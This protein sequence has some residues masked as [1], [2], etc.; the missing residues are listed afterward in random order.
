MITNEKIEK[1]IEIWKKDLLDLSLRN[2]LINYKTR[3]TSSIPILEPSI[4]DIF[5]TLVIKERSMTFTPIPSEENDEEDI[6]YKKQR[7]APREILCNLEDKDLNLALNRLR[8]RAKTSYEEMGINTLFIAFGFIKWSENSTSKNPL[9]SPILLVPVEI[10]RKNLASKC[11]I[12][13]I[14]EDIVINPTLAKKLEEF[15]IN[16]NEIY[17]PTSTLDKVF[18]KELFEKVAEIIE[19]FIGWEIIEKA[20]ISLF[21]F[22]K[23]SMYMDL[24]KYSHLFLEN[25]VLK[26]IANEQTV[27]L[28]EINVENINDLDSIDDPFNSFQV[29]DADS[30]QQEAI[31][32]IKK[33]ASL[34]IQGPPGTGKS[35]TI[36]N[37]IAESL[38]Q[39]KTVLFVSEKKAALEV[40]KKRLDNCGLGDFCLE[41]HSKK[42]RKRVVL[43]ELERT[44]NQERNRLLDTN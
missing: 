17:E 12:R 44:L 5:E 20:E 14:D 18:L 27:K 36:A 11:E 29:L 1:K 40:V 15:G 34:V 23:L 28:S 31:H 33:G 30:S 6:D 3:K 7:L 38:G 16:L 8:L 35:Q 13:V 42:T 4:T 26:A 2:R 19:N 37:I 25:P 21:S 32:L 22:A 39:N 41:L 9:L 24:E 43:D 10:I